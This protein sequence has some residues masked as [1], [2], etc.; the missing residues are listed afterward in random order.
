MRIESEA[1][2]QVPET[3]CLMEYF[4]SHCLPI[5]YC[6]E[7]PSRITWRKLRSRF[8]L[9]V[10]KVFLNELSFIISRTGQKVKAVRYEQHTDTDSQ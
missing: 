7:G 1:E 5:L 6:L 10:K 4:E 2:L 8:Q 3:Q 9:C